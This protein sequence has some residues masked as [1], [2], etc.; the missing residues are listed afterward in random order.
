MVFGLY[1]SGPNWSN[2]IYPKKKRIKIID[3][4]CYNSAT[5]PMR[6][7]FTCPQASLADSQSSS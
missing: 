4:M 5:F 1:V 3:G 6:A 7:W 2:L